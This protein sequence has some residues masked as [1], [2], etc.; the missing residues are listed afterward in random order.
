MGGSSL[1]GTVKFY[2]EFLSGNSFNKSP[3][4]EKKGDILQFGKGGRRARLQ[5]AQRPTRPCRG[6]AD[7]RPPRSLFLIDFAYWNAFKLS[8]K[9]SMPLSGRSR[10]ADSGTPSETFVARIYAL[11]KARKLE[12]ILINVP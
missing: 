8:R 6:A 12:M 1:P 2:Q 3:P 7:S 10:R 9:L 4:K 5:R 11:F